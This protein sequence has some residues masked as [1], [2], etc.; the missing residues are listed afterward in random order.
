MT[1]GLALLLLLAAEQPSLAL[2]ACHWEVACVEA[3]S[4]PRCSVRNCGGPPPLS[5]PLEAPAL[6]V[7]IAAVAVEQAL[8]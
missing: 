2:L 1:A 6:K 8:A 4:R 3:A 5:P 7:H